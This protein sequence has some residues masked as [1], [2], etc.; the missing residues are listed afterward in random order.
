MRDMC[1]LQDSDRVGTHREAAT[2]WKLGYLDDVRK[3]LTLITSG[4]MTDPFSMKEEGD[5]ISPMINIATGVRMPVVLTER[6]V[7]YFEIGTAQSDDKMC[8]TE[9]E[10]QQHNVLGFLRNVK[11]NTFA[12]LV[13]KKTLKLVYEKVHVINDDRE[14]FCRL[15]FAAKSRSSIWK[16]SLATSCEQYISPWSIQMAVWG[17][18]TRVYSWLC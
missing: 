17:K 2:I 9:T 3:L 16:M 12:S 6:L 14:L 13:K 1:A 10:Y 4:L 5:D 15:V 8:G 11:I 18:P 7:S